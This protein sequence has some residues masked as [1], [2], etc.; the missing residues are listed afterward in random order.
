MSDASSYRGGECDDRDKIEDMTLSSSGTPKDN[1]TSL[2]GNVVNDSS[3]GRSGKCNNRD[4]IEDMT[5]SSGT[6]KDNNASLKGKLLLC[7]VNKSWQL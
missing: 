4:E 3:S 6:P 1:N 2:K 7:S 5:L